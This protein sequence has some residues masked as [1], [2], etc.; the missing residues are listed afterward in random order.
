M[1]KKYLSIAVGTA[2]GMAMIV[3][4][5]AQTPA[6]TNTNQGHMMRQN[7]QQND[8]T[9]KTDNRG[10]FGNNSQMMIRPT[11]IGTVTSISGNTITLSGHQ[12]KDKGDPSLPA[13]TFTVDATKATIYKNRATTTLSS[14]ISG[15]TLN[16]E[17]ALT[18]TTIVAT[19]IHNSAMMGG[20]RGGRQGGMMGN[21][22][23]TQAMVQL[24]GNGL[25]IVAGTISAIN[26][27]TITLTNKSNVTYTV[28]VTSA[29]IMV[30]NAVATV[31]SIAIGDTVIVQGTVQGNA[32]TAST[33]IDEGTSKVIA[34]SGQPSG[35]TKAQGFL[36]GLGGFFSHMFGF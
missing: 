5:F 10:S 16:V 4:T 14:I 3:P 26:G 2:T 7:H 1:N 15:D 17:G 32:I 33:L 29:K 35:T 8:A 20:N 30:K 11:V 21:N 12:T 34:T 6:P 25:P 24:Q 23:A 31:S 22:L 19:T 9:G 18:G 36:G 28:D 27:N 13:S